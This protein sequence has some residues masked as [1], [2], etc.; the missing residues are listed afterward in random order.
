MAAFDLV[1]VGA[2]TAGL[3]CA[4]AA[5]HE[6]AR[7]LLVEKAAEV[8]GTLH[9][10][11]GH[12]SAGG[13]RRQ[14]ERGIEDSPDL[15]LEDCERISGGTADPTLIDKAA[16]LAPGTVDWLDDHGF[17][18][19]PECPRLVYGHEP[20]SV[21]RTVYGVDEARS[22]LRV[23]ERLITPRIASGEIDLWLE[24]PVTRLLVED[25]RVVG[26]EVQPPDAEP[27]RA[28]ANAVVLASG[29]YAA[30]PEIF[31]GL[32]GRPLVSAARETSTG[33]A[34]ALTEPLGARVRGKDAL[35][36]TF[37]GLP[38]PG[39]PGRARWND[40]PLL[41]ATERAPWEIY[42]DRHGERFVAE[43]EPSMHAKEV[44]LLGLPDLTFW[45]VFDER[46]VSESE[47]LIFGWSAERLREAAGTREGFHRGSNLEELADRAG[48]DAAGLVATVSRYNRDLATG[49]ADETGRSVRPA[50]IETPPFY[51]LRNHGITL[52]TF[53]GLDVDES[54]AVRR[55]DGSTVAGLY[56]AGEV[57]GARATCGCAFLG[58]MMITPALSFGRELGRRLGRR[59][60][61]S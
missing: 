51:A 11:G 35:M 47:H 49:A 21:A 33:D 14:S 48:I 32:H 52:I 16:K 46:A 7:V 15:H 29:G 37:G 8:G 13:T 17:D 55:E 26:V 61:R 42:V 39:R 24:S 34:F 10:S 57:L 36:P 4:I 27:R 45:T 54:L 53:A 43:D 20:Y 5:A 30:A 41:V 58:G 9:V 2:G 25:D 18:F 56:A 44:A 22:I 59:F 19:A 31:E 23:L 50:A 40:R 3:P 60:A 1:V 38:E 6:G 28:R 12:M